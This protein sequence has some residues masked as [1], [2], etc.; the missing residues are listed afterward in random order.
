MRVEVRGQWSL[1][2]SR[3]NG[4]RAVYPLWRAGFPQLF[5]AIKGLGGNA[6]L[7]MLPNESH[8]YRARESIPH[9]LAETS[10]WLERYVK[11]AA[12][13]EPVAAKK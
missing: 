6:R 4:L 9:M 8:G 2:H 12:V 7:V 3:R 10:E 11:N 5:D 13:E 1:H